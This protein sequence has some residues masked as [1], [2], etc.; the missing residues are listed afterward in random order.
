MSKRA[1]HLSQQVLHIEGEILSTLGIK[2]GI[3]CGGWLRSAIVR[4]QKV[5]QISERIL[6]VHMNKMMSIT[7]GNDKTNHTSV[8]MCVF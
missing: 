2:T 3:A 6:G 5:I 1:H 4:L 8:K 7:E